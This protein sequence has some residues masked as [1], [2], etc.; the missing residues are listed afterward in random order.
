MSEVN[1][2]PVLA[3]VVPSVSHLEG[4]KKAIT[5]I[6]NVQLVFTG[7][8][9]GSSK[10]KDDSGEKCERLTLQ[11][12]QDGQKHIVFTSSEVL[13]EQLKSFIKAMPDAKCFRATIKRVDNKFLKFVV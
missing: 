13:I 2:I 3:E 9:F 4:S 10:F 11:F 1:P 8:K 5:D 6:L 7:W 12:E